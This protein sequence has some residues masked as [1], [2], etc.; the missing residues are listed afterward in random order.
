M[1]NHAQPNYICPLCLAADGTESTQTMMMQ[2]DIFY[3]DEL[4]IAAVNSKFYTSNPGHIIIFPASHFEHLYD[5]PEQIST[6]I[7]KLSQKVALALKE[8]RKADGVM[9][10][11]NNEPASG[12]HAFHYH[13]HI[14]PRFDNDNFSQ[15]QSDVKVADPEDRKPFSAAL[16]EY[17]SRIDS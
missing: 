1:H 15:N 14:I 5:L 6:H 12:Q 16:K 13:M 11:Q 4:V 17:F 2:D 10:V 8:T 9:I 7:M 3:R